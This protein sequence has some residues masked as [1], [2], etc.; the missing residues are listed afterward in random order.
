MTILENVCSRCRFP[1]NYNM[2]NLWRFMSLKTKNK[3]KYKRI[4]N[5]KLFNQLKLRIKS[6]LIN[7]MVQKIYLLYKS[8]TVTEIR[9]NFLS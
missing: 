5:K 7:L 1:F 4:F 8:R 6:L 3:T 2:G 9:V